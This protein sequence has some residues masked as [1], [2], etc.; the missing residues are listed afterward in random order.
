MRYRAIIECDN[1][2]FA[3]APERE[4]ARILR[5]LA[6]EVE[7]TGSIDQL[8]TLR[9]VNGNSVGE[10]ESDNSPTGYHPWRI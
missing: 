7:R 3:D 10:A 8:V 6:D 1:A 9:D 5:D 2:A 4:V